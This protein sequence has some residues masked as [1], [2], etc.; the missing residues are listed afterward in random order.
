MWKITLP[1]SHENDHR[2]N[3]PQVYAKDGGGVHVESESINGLC[4][5]GGGE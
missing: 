4:K 2:R 3:N 5:T 1:N